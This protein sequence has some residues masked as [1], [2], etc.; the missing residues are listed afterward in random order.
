[1]ARRSCRPLGAED[2][3]GHGLRGQKK[4]LC[5]LGPPQATLLGAMYESCFMHVQ[6]TKEFILWVDNGVSYA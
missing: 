2:Y 5:T 6:P 1:M 4:G 3:F